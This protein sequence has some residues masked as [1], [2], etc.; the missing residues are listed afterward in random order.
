MTSVAHA[1]N[2]D[3]GT[4]KTYT[5]L[6][7]LQAAKG[8]S[9]NDGD[10]I[11]LYSDDNSLIAPFNFGSKNI[12][13]RGSGKITPDT[14]SNIRFALGSGKI[15]IDSVSLE[16]NGFFTTAAGGVF[17][18]DPNVRLEIS[19]GTNKFN[20]N[21]AIGGDTSNGAV[22]YT[23]NR[24]DISGGT[25]TFTANEVTGYGGVIRASIFS[26]SD[27]TNLFTDN[28]AE[29]GGGAVWGQ[30]IN[31]SGGTNTFERNIID[32]WSGG[33]LRS[34]GAVT[35]SGGIN[36]FTENKTQ[37]SGSQGG[38][39]F[40]TTIVEL[41]GS[42]SNTFTN[43]FAYDYGGAIYGWGGVTLSGATNNFT[44]N[45]AN[46]NAGAVGGGSII[47]SGGANTF[48][49]NS[50]AGANGQGG[51]IAGFVI[52]LSNGTNIFT[53]NKITGANGQGGAIA[54]IYDISTSS[55]ITLSGG[56]NTFG[57]AA[58]ADGNTA[59]YGGVIYASGNVLLSATSAVAGDFNRFE[60]NSA[61][62]AGGVIYSDGIGQSVTILGG[63]NTFKNNS[64]TQFG[65]AIFSD[66]FEISNGTNLF[67]NNAAEYGG[68]IHGGYIDSTATLSGGTNTFTGNKAESGGAINS[69]NIYLSGGTN[70]FTGNETTVS[71][72]TGGAIIGHTIEFSDGEN[73]FTSNKA[74]SG[75]ALH[76]VITNFSGGENIFSGNIATNFGNGSGGAIYN[77]HT[78][79]FSG[80]ENIFTGNQAI[81]SSSYGGAIYGA[82]INFTGGQ[83]TFG[84]DAKTDGNTSDFYGGA[85]YATGN[86]LFSNT[87]AQ[88]GDFNL[89][90]NNSTVEAGG[91]IYTSGTVTFANGTNTFTA[92]EAKGVSQ[93][94]GYTVGGA[95]SIAGT[96]T[97]SGGTNTFTGN[98][99]H[100][101]SS[102]IGGG[103]ISSGNNILFS[104]GT[105]SFSGNQSL[106]SYGSGSGYG[107]AIFNS[108][109][110]GSRSITFSGGTNSFTGNTAKTYGGAIYAGSVS[111]GVSTV[112]IS[113]GTNEFI[114][115]EAAGG[116]AIWGNFSTINIGLAGSTDTLLFENNKALAY[117]GGAIGNISGNVNIL[118]GAN[119]FKTNSAV[120]DGGAISSG[121]TTNIVNIF[122]GTN[123]FT[124][125]LATGSSGKGG[126]IYSAGVNITGGQNTF[127]GIFTVDINKA[128]Q[129]GAIF[130]S[131][132]FT[133]SA[134]TA[135][136]GDYNLFQYNL[137]TD[138]GGAI[139]CNGTVAISNGTNTFMANQV[140]GL[141][142]QGGAIFSNNSISISN[143]ENIFIANKAAFGGALHGAAI[144]LSGGENTFSGNIASIPG[145]HGG[146][147]YASNTVTFSGGINI[148]TGNQSQGVS[149]NASGGAVYGAAINFT[150]GQNT[151]GGAIA[152]SGN[153]SDQYGGAIY[154]SGNILLST[155]AAGDFILFQ[156]NSAN[157][158][159]AI[160]SD[161]TVTLSSGTNTFESNMAKGANSYGGA[162]FSGTVNLLS[163]EN[164]FKT[165]SAAG[166]TIGN[167]GGAIYG[168]TI[169]LSGATTD[170]FNWFENNSVQNNGGAIYGTTI[171]LLSGANTFKENT[172]KIFGGAI[173][174]NKI[175]IEDGTN[176]FIGNKTNGPDAGDGG[177]AIAVGGTNGFL[178]ISDGANLFSGNTTTNYGGA[179]YGNP[180]STITIEGGTNDFTGNKAT[181]SGGAIYGDSS[182]STILLSGG[183]N[184]FTSNQATTDGGAI[185]G[186][187]VTLSGGKNTFGGTI[188]SDGN[189]ARS[190]GAIYGTD[191]TLSDDDA[192]SGDYNLFE[193]N[194]ATTQGGGAIWGNS[195]TLDSGTSTF[196]S[197]TVTGTSGS[198][199]AIYGYTTVT[200]ADGVNTFQNNQATGTNSNGGAIYGSGISITGGLNK[201]ENNS[202]A[203]LFGYGY[204]GAIGSSGTVSI[205]NGTNIFIGN[206]TTGMSTRG[207]AIGSV[208]AVTI[209]GGTNTFQSNAAAANSGNGGAIHSDD[210]ITLSGGKNLF[211]GDS[212]SEG[213]TAYRGGAISGDTGTTI[214]LSGTGTDYNK[215]KNN[216]AVSAGGAIY[217]DSVALSGGTN[218]FELNKVTSNYNGGAIYANN[219]DIS[220]G[221]N[222]F[223]G[224]TTG[225]SGGAIGGNSVTISGGTNIFTENTTTGTAGSP[226]IGGGAIVARDTLMIIGGINTFENNL[227]ASSGGAI[228]AHADAT[229]IAQTG[230]G[231][232]DIKFQGNKANNS[233]NAIYLYNNGGGHTLTL[234]AAADRSIL[235]YDPIASN[236]SWRD[237]AIDINGGIN[238]SGVTGGTIL[239]DT[240]KSNVYGNSIVYG[241]TMKLTN[242]ATYG[243]GVTNPSF[244]LNDGATLLSDVKGNTILAETITISGSSI[245]AFDMT[246]AVAVGG[247]TPTTNLILNGTTINSLIDSQ[248]VNVVN[249]TGS[250]GIYNLAKSNVTNSF[251]D[252][253]NTSIGAILLINGSA[254][255]NVGRSHYGLQVADSDGLTKNVLQLAAT[256]QN[257]VVLWK[258]TVDGT[259]GT[260]TG[261]WDGQ[262][263]S[264]NIGPPVG[265]DLNHDAYFVNGDA[266]WF[267]GSGGTIAIQSGGV[268]IAKQAAVE[269][270]NGPNN[271]INPGMEI[272]S[273]NWVFTGGAIN[274]GAILISGG[275]SIDPTSI[276]FDTRTMNQR[277]TVANGVNTI[278]K[279][280][281]G[282]TV[283][284]SNFVNAAMGGAVTGTNNSTITFGETGSTSTLLFSDNQGSYGGAIYAYD[285]IFSGG[286]NTFERNTANASHGGA[287]FGNNVTISS[288]INTFD[289]NQVVGS[290]GTTDGGGAIYTQYDVNIENGTNTF[291]NNS[292]ASGDG[293]A[294]RSGTVT[295]DDGL[296][297]FGDN[298]TKGGRGTGGAIHSGTVEIAGGTN[299][300]ERNETDGTNGNGGAIH[301]STF[302]G[303]GIVE[304]TGGTNTFEDN[305]AKGDSGSGG[306]IYTDILKI[307]GG[308]STF[309]G[310]TAEGTNGRGGAVYAIN[311][312]TL[313]A[314]D[315]VDN[316]NITFQGNTDSTGA[317]AIYVENDGNNKTLTLAAETGRSILF[318]DP[319][320]SSSNNPNLT[321]D[322]NTTDGGTS[323]TAGTILFDRYHSNV[324]GITTVY[325]GIMQL[326]NGA[327]YGAGY[328]NQSFTLNAD[329]TLL[330]DVKSNKI[331]ASTITISGSSIL[332]FDMTNAVAQGG[333]TPTTNL[334]L[335]GAT[336][337]SPALKQ[338]VDVTNFTGGNGTYNL[339]K[340]NAANSFGNWDVVGGTDSVKLLIGGVAPTNIGRTHYGLKVADSD[341]LTK[342][343]LQLA[344]TTQN[345]VVLWNV[346]GNGTWNI[347]DTNW[348]GQNTLA[349]TGPPA[350]VN[351]GGDAYFVNGDAVWFSGTGG[352]IAIQS[353]GVTI[354]AQAAVNGGNH[355]NPGMEISG[356]NWIF[357]G[358]EILG[359]GVLP[360]GSHTNGAIL[361]SGNGSISFDTRVMNQDIAMTNGRTVGIKA[362]DGAEVTF[363]GFS[364]YR[365]GAVT[366]DVGNSND[367]TSTINL[368]E[369]LSTGTLVF[370]N[371]SAGDYGGAIYGGSVNI[372]DGTNT[373]TNNSSNNWGGAI[374]ASNSGG[375]VSISGGTNT[376][377][378]NVAK[379]V[380][381][382]INSSSGATISGGTNTFKKNTLDNAGSHGGAMY[383]MGTTTI[384]G[385]TNTFEENTANGTGGAISSTG[386]TEI[387]SGTNV[388]KNNSALTSVGIG[389]AIYGL[390]IN[391]TGGENTFE[392]NTAGNLGGA[393]FAGNNI[394]LIA[395]NGVGNGD[396]TFKD[397]TDST[398]ANAIYMS[399]NSGNKILTLAA[400]SDRKIL[401]YDSVASDSTR[402]NLV[403]DMNNGG[404]YT[405]TILFDQHR[406]DVYG[407]TTVYDGTMQLTGGA[408]YGAAY[409]GG[410][411]TLKNGAT[412]FSDVKE[413]TIQAKNINL[414]G[415]SILA[416]SMTGAIK[417]GETNATTNLLLKGT[418]I[419]STFSS[420]KVNV[421]SF[422]GVTGTYNLAVGNAGSFTDW[423]DAVL[424]LD[425]FVPANTR[426]TFG[427]VVDSTYATDDTLQLATVIQNGLVKWNTAIGGNWDTG[428]G[429]W[430]GQD[431]TLY[432]G[433]D[434][435]VSGVDLSG[436]TK[437]VNGDAVWFAGSGGTIAIQA[438][439]VTIAKQAAIDGG[440]HVNP[441][442]EISAGDWIFTGGNITGGGILISGG[443]SS[444]P[445][446][447]SFGGTDRQVTQHIEVANGVHTAV[448]AEAGAKVTFK[449][450][451][452]TN[453]GAIKGD[454]NSVINLGGAGT[455]VFSDNT[456][457]GNGGAVSGNIVNVGSGTNTFTNNT[458][459]MFG[460]AV[461]A[462]DTSISNGTNTFTENTAKFGGSI[463]NMYENT[464]ISGG[465]NIFENNTAEHGGAIH[466]ENYTGTGLFTI[467][468]GTNTF[469]DNEATGGALF[470]YGGAINTKSDIV[471]SDGTNTFEDNSA[472]TLGGA[473]FGE[474]ALEISGGTNTFKTN[475]AESGGAI[476]A[477]NATDKEIVISGGTNQF[478]GNSA[479]GTNPSDGGGAI[480]AVGNL[481]MIGGTN[482]FEGNTATHLGGA[483][484]AL[485]DVTLI[486]DDDDIAFEGNMAGSTPAPNAIYMDNLTTN[487]MT[488]AAEAGK[489]I[490][491]YDPIT[492]TADR[493]NLTIDINTTDGG[494]SATTGTVLFDQYHSE[495]Y[496]NTTVYGGTMQL[497]KG[498][499]Y[500]A[501]T[502][503]GTFT[504]KDDATLLSDTK[505]NTI[506]AGTINLE[507]ESILAFDMTGA[508]KV[509]DIT[510]ITTNL[511]LEGTLITSTFSSQAVNIV[512]FAGGTGTFNLAIGDAGTFTN[513]DGADLMI[514]GAAPPT[515]GR[516]TYG[517]QV[518]TTTS[519]NDTLQLATV[520]KNG[521]V[522]WN[523]TGNGEWNANADNWEGQDT[524]GHYS[525]NGIDLEQDEYFVYGDAVWFDGTG[526]TINIQSGGVTITERVAV[527][528]V[529]HVNFGMEIS[530]GD[531][532]FTGGDIT[533]GAIL[534]SDN[535][536]AP[537]HGVG[538][539]SFSS[540]IMKQRII[541]N[542]DVTA[543]IKAEN[544]ATVTF[545]GLSSTYV[546]GAI[547]GGSGSTIN[548]GAA[549]STGTLI[550]SNNTA[551]VFGGAIFGDTINIIGGTSTF[552]N[553]SAN[554][555]GGAIFANEDVTLIAKSGTGNSDMTFQGNTDSTGANAI[556]MNNNS[557][558]TLTLAAEAD[559]SILFYDPI[560]SD[561]GNPDLMVRINNDGTNTYAGTIL[562]DQYHSKLY[563]DTTVY[564][565]TMQLTNG[566]TYGAANNIGSFTL[567]NSATLL[568]DVY[569]NTIMANTIDFE[570]GSILMFDLTGAVKLG[571][572]GATTNLIL[573][574]TTVVALGQKI[575]EGTIN[576][577]NLNF[578]GL[579]AG[580][581]ITLVDSG[582]NSQTAASGTLAILSQV[583]SG[584][585]QLAID[586][587]AQYLYLQI[588][589]GSNWTDLDDDDLR[590][591]AK[592]IPDVLDEMDPNSPV[593]EELRKYGT[594]EEMVRVINEMPGDIFANAQFAVADLRKKFN[595]QLPTHRYFW[596][597]CISSSSDSYNKGWYPEN[598]TK[599]DER[600]CD[601]FATK[602]WAT[603]SGLYVNRSAAGGYS[604]YDLGN[605]GLM[606]GKSWRIQKNN[607]IGAAF[608]YDYS[609]IE[610]QDVSQNDNMQ[611][612][613]FAVYGSYMR[614]YYFADWN[615]GYAKNWHETKRVVG[616][617]IAK[618]K[619]DDHLFSLNATMGRRIGAWSPSIGVELIQVWSPSHTETGSVYNLAVEKG[620]YMSLEIPIGM[621]WSKALTI[622]GDRIPWVNESRQLNLT[623]EVYA[624]WVPQLGDRDSSMMTS[625]ASGS[626]SFRVSSGDFGTQH[627]R[628]GTGLTARFSNSLSASVN[629][630]ATVYKGQIR[631]MAGASMTI[632]F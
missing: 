432:A 385:G 573:D 211:G 273:G 148:F 593:I 73:S 263:A 2:Y 586:N 285:V 407:T 11:T 393:I 186:K 80:G 451:N 595:S 99:A 435:S 232:G 191:I 283:T 281:S 334:I 361:F 352:T 537:G 179:I 428:T 460:G 314:K 518:A 123:T 275:T 500:G 45:K 151:F 294:I 313:I 238:A 478:L 396:I 27:G 265:T 423:D 255:L 43:N 590:P 234:A 521:V 322:I 445:S 570:T 38:A 499:T 490:L 170:D 403:I 614:G 327:I 606:A 52:T 382:A 386:T 571:E 599:I 421:V 560:T 585:A 472:D 206:S 118:G 82:A 291:T 479:T 470:S 144:D 167:G 487:T 105:N 21:K 204:G 44:N 64:A 580:D 578:Y 345:G 420:Q 139:Y 616:G 339:A 493:Q 161:S 213:N 394:T 533:G 292:V 522:L 33:A 461:Y 529:D 539:A 589:G 56:K 582:A 471:I 209:S 356:G 241:G 373:F 277:V 300:F 198:G 311:S 42:G 104:G 523:K 433:T 250:N 193:N 367:A 303:D 588:Q 272:S 621:Q 237:L 246:N 344:K 248:T 264:S 512:S 23:E 412:L 197:N 28:F 379:N 108:V 88:A 30:T 372:I 127:G 381:G 215:F 48:D 417:Q 545:D 538:S 532:V 63:T 365:G 631:Q 584:D 362:E 247:G 376:F 505:S 409:D 389:G 296:N 509:E 577:T 391:V 377:E 473:I 348:N 369:A 341:G 464:T 528:G 280:E 346:P 207:G 467:S 395:K 92:N 548:L 605:G 592:P 84:G 527:N 525:G 140:T 568:S 132:D 442:M 289:G 15:T 323:S 620:D 567:N 69:V 549:N 333:G 225:Q 317:N 611:S 531:W 454:T 26:I 267:H 75:G 304:I 357:T 617:T 230:T 96:V 295:I 147:I 561:S 594:E 231:N 404:G 62:Q 66:L 608:G 81:G 107:G 383:V 16:F 309:E 565:G 271:H 101:A 554:T 61:S 196:R 70:S 142:G 3:V 410:T 59:M 474:K 249:F 189:T 115:N 284:F 485:R 516:A 85:I 154:S 87:S 106:N 226:D 439:G 604:G 507:D 293:G 572:A 181:K 544:G 308:T 438:A 411:F 457:S 551:D 607:M 597:A 492:S 452:A 222:T 347:T 252:W 18:A 581:K 564:G 10:T 143:G 351:L 424:T 483:I 306:A 72:G 14:G 13:L 398:G 219:V 535:S 282:A 618:S 57:G 116:G 402:Q 400:E 125:N 312:V 579:Q 160:Y 203:G 513:W 321:I 446:S 95:I 320:V 278:I 297:T 236:T 466:Q 212:T 422:S 366:G 174:G 17:A 331:Q 360:S 188:A 462:S 130:V 180:D 630:D 419:T 502:T 484:Y 397:N 392:G 91:A 266:V 359:G 368:G 133:L 223:T 501:D 510:G 194:K 162:I 5:T 286:T 318:Y 600:R 558:N 332:A 431:T 244:T 259:W 136:A 480:Y 50:V 78:T 426:A 41:K 217:G 418:S 8:A 443:S 609:R 378:E 626:P 380:G 71:G 152:T 613:D 587:D 486:A 541:V 98:L 534:F 336:I 166:I 343:V 425:G 171:N 159:G 51:A 32:I 455:L 519:T 449:N 596:D 254:P 113:A 335:N 459:S 218:I 511:F 498:A 25:N 441:G 240:Y 183:A 54:G 526:G 625:F 22:I 514:N 35:I 619:Y 76:S 448:K 7:S 39:I 53:N 416:F 163:G 508:V 192:V 102:I 325:G 543:T 128:S 444:D 37:L 354:A 342:N 463:Y 220:S 413:N 90:K 627:F 576:V 489:S 155:T 110:S 547:N 315:G 387:S 77:T 370:S 29:R 330:S 145:G 477:G 58:V 488:L 169:N 190:G 491:F 119:T 316:G 468:G 156:N 328:G 187:T 481:S 74:S 495:V 602:L 19:G 358:G 164:T 112:N 353:E 575:G 114:G 555:L 406:S 506:K 583:G 305:K 251:E 349:N 319:V 124:G 494:T 239:F 329:A 405:G 628:L 242:G 270:G 109:S 20:G 195:V 497:T 216:S 612:L 310:N 298:A 546:G 384:S 482:T 503:V 157:V 260:N 122:G 276:S 120:L 205:S 253:D 542:N 176:E 437:F 184:T 530:S 603:P 224:N 399:N 569:S 453:G 221:M 552:T 36:T 427:L 557:S 89:F 34:A 257:G 182:S 456:A 103:A 126:A 93:Y 290:N 24:V 566:A 350:G 146:A 450:F 476:R 202:V 326:T 214:T 408:T 165:N 67:E 574:G 49:S 210:D 440:D 235:F 134:A 94:T 129:G 149:D 624:F 475:T 168:T 55:I 337:N 172:A 245:L 208:G 100:G 414:E 185:W 1:A 31:I 601:E 504:L 117:S 137:A 563:G 515:S 83:N 135:I 269:D 178:T 256:V 355:I 6:K 229:L 65:G 388:F 268:T 158:G 496:G 622:S 429:N 233:P 371:N 307:A 9:W 615:F 375:G 46:V 447:I 598:W 153:R 302:F 430:D 261:N 363:D 550:F 86:I 520:I 434:T 177:G 288:G 401:F 540:R 279:A 138:A 632:R 47:L 469:L 436:E 175:T 299:T 173:Y 324:R 243:S 524:T 559:R 374:Y 340:S 150:G 301:T 97:F 390:T 287:V 556:Y 465:T 228:H 60:N 227:S 131:A 458:A 623:P 562:F 274:G 199:G 415:S 40:G 610:M 121:S 141:N 12:T 338:T 79:T 364:K 200:L 553:N 258:G 262:N 68:A 201:F 517:L 4:G 536:N 111:T 629:Y 591:N